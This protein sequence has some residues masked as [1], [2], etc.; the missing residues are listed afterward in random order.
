M[1]KICLPHAMAA[2]ESHAMSKRMRELSRKS[3]RVGRAEWYFSEA[4]PGMVRIGIIFK[5]FNRNYRFRGKPWILI[6]GEYAIPWL[7]LEPVYYKW[8]GKVGREMETMARIL[9]NSQAVRDL[10]YMGGWPI[11]KQRGQRRMAK[12]RAWGRH[13]SLPKNAIDEI[14]RMAAKEMINSLSGV[15]K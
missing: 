14:A 1:S 9:N 13:K 12:G 2:F 3:R 5:P 6:G 7:D 8:T 10:Q 11:K 4:H 15:K